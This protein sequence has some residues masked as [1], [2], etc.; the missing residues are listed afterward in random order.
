M[1]DLGKKNVRFNTRFDDIECQ[2]YGDDGTEIITT[3]D[4]ILNNIY[5]ENVKKYIIEK[6]SQ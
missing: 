6:L 2:N 4:T 3:V 5:D 1:D